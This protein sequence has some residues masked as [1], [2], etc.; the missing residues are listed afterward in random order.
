MHTGCLDAILCQGPPPRGFFGGGGAMACH[1]DGEGI[2]ARRR[3]LLR[4]W[5]CWWCVGL[6]HWLVRRRRR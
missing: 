6:P 5:V 2:F 1:A 4:D 3:L